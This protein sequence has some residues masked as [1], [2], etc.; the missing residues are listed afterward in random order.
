MLGVPV[1]IGISIISSTEWKIRFNVRGKLVNIP[2]GAGSSQ[3]WPAPIKIG[4][5]FS[6]RCVDI[7]CHGN[8]IGCTPHNKRGMISISFYNIPGLFQSKC[9][10]SRIILGSSIPGIHPVTLIESLPAHNPIF[11][12]R[13]KY[14]IR[15]RR[16]IFTCYHI[17][18]GFC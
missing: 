6:Q 2:G 16:C 18:I 11:V 5:I 8:L 15:R 3:E 9:M 17:Y 12:I 7:L 4:Y 10:V 1:I 13:I 14:N